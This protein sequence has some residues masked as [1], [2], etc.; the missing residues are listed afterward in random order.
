M[1]DP[2]ST[3]IK[4][5]SQF[6]SDLRV[7]PLV[8]VS[9]LVADQPERP[10]EGAGGGCGVILELT[11]IDFC[12]AVYEAAPKGFSPDVCCRSCAAPAVSAESAAAGRGSSLGCVQ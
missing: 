4:R 3:A 8:W 9:F 5:E 12:W 6:F 10:R 2:R 7:L 1:E 11:S